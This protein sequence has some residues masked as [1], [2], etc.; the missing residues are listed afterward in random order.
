MEQDNLNKLGRY[1]DLVAEFK[2]NGFTEQQ[3]EYLIK[4]LRDFIPLP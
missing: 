1:W 2:Q 3:A 4:L